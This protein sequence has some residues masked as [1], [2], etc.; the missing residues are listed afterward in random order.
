ME[1]MWP[2]SICLPAILLFLCSGNLSYYLCVLHELIFGIHLCGVTLFV[3]NSRKGRKKAMALM[4]ERHEA[5][6]E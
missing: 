3:R 5:K 2:E 4:L 6:N 1:P